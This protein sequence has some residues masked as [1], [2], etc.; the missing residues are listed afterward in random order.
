MEGGREGGRGS[1]LEASR[2]DE[3]EAGERDGECGRENRE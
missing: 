1:V 3:E 2:E